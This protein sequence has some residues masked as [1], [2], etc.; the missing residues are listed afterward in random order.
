MIDPAGTADRVERK[1]RLEMTWKLLALLMFVLL[2]PGALSLY[3]NRNS[4]RQEISWRKKSLFMRQGDD[5]VSPP[6]D[7]ERYP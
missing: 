6:V 2:S 1:E 3:G 5:L 7:R 4:P